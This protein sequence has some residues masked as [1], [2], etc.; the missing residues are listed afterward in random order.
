MYVRLLAHPSVCH[1]NFT[2][3]AEISATSSAP[4][5]QSAPVYCE[6][7]CVCRY[8]LYFEMLKRS[9]LAASVVHLRVNAFM[10]TGHTKHLIVMIPG[11]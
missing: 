4:L 11:R 10:L 9:T 3:A 2:D 5:R 8:K 1:A 6:N 7:L